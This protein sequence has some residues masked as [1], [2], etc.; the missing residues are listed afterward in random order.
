[1]DGEDFLEEP[2]SFGECKSYDFTTT[3]H[4]SA[5]TTPDKEIHVSVRKRGDWVTVVIPDILSES[6]GSPGVITIDPFL[7]SELLGFFKRNR[8]FA[9]LG[10]NTN[11]SST[12]LIT[13]NTIINM[14]EGGK[15]VIH[16][17]QK[18]VKTNGETATIVEFTTNNNKIGSFSTQFT[19]VIDDRHSFNGQLFYS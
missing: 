19:Y 11:S 14:Y 4:C 8:F 18:F 10:K 1:M 7:P 13:V 16:P 17:F 12:T 3:A 5:F 9:G 6:N 2:Y 15:I